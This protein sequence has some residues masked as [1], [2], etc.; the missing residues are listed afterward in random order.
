MSR[1]PI[2]GGVSFR[3]SLPLRPSF[4]LSAPAQFSRF[5]FHFPISHFPLSVFSKSFPCHTSGISPVTPSFA[6][7]PQILSCKLFACHTSDTPLLPKVESPQAVERPRIAVGVAGIGCPYK[8]K[9]E[10]VGIRLRISLSAGRLTRR[11]ALGLLSTAARCYG[12]FSRGGSDQASRTFPF[13]GN[14]EPL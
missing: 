13:T 9:D 1:T 3:P 5:A 7:D 8:R 11:A 10:A 14:P 12:K 2:S 4:P 6:T